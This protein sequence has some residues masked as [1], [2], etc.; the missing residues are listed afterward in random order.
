LLL[1]KNPERIGELW[2]AMYD[3]TLPFG[4]K[5]IAIMAI[6]G[7]DLAL[8]DLKGKAEMKS[9][10][11]LLGGIRHARIPVYAT[12]WGPLKPEVIASYR[13]FK[14]HVENQPGLTT[15]QAV[16]DLVKRTREQLG[17]D[18]SLML[19][20]WMKW[21][22][23]TTLA[24]AEKV[25]GYHVDW[26]E[27]PLPADDWAGYAELSRRCPIPIAGGEHEFTAAGF[28]PLIDQR[29]H[30]VLQ[31]DVCWCGG[32]TELVKIYEQ[33][34]RAGL[35]VCPHRGGEV[36]ALPALAALDPQPLAES[37]RPW[38][39]WV[40]GQPPVVDGLISPSDEPGFGVRIDEKKL[41]HV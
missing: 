33:A 5:G 14:L 6:S 8:W 32:M 38:M 13:A 27:E 12:V 31:P 7:V 15:V 3:A 10:A 17:P 4:R 40:E 1:G 24:V 9:V 16:V 28:A 19:D 2:R 22:I 34:G 21:D 26:I 37:G 39:T 25:K 41:V 11:Q 20:A 29:L 18:R 35:K 36:W 23:P 30:Q